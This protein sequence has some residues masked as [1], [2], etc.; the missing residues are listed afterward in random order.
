MTT[1]EIRDIFGPYFENIN[2][3]LSELKVSINEIKKELAVD[4]DQLVRTISQIEIIQATI[5]ENK[6]SEA[7][8]GR[9]FNKR[10]EDVE[11]YVIEDKEETAKGKLE[12]YKQMIKM[13]TFGAGGGGVVTAALKLLGV[14]A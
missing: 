7:V 2:R 12:N 10:L 14:G 11:Q 6:E 13:G 9:Q 4:H 5:K 8:F 1:Q 3:D